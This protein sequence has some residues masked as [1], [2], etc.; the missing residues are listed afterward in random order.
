MY[1]CVYTDF[2]DVDDP[3]YEAAHIYLTSHIMDEALFPI[4]QHRGLRQYLKTFK[5]L[6]IEFL[7]SEPQVG[8]G[9]LCV[10]MCRCV[11]VCVCMC[12]CVCVCVRVLYVCLCVC[13]CVHTAA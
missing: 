3:K 10:S 11:C 4:K 8:G 1:V 2:A 9:C 7:A 13:G 12:L 6:N 5:E